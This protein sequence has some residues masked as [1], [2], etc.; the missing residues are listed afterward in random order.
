MFFAFNV[1]EISQT[2]LKRLDDQAWIVDVA[3]SSD[4]TDTWDFIRLLRLG[5]MT[6]QDKANQQKDS[7]HA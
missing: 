3:S 7:F 2:L 1:A 5:K 6:H 4:V